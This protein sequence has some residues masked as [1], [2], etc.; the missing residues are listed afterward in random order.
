MYGAPGSSGPA[1]GCRRP[2]PAHWAVL[3]GAGVFLAGC[4]SMPDV[5]DPDDGPEAACRAFFHELDAQVAS[6]GVRDGIGEPPE[7]FPYLRATRF[8]NSFHEQ[9]GD[10]AVR[11]AWLDTAQETDRA[12]RSLELR[13]LD[14][15]AVDGL[16]MPETVAHAQEAIAH[17]GALL[18]EADALDADHGP[19]REAADALTVPD[20]YVTWQRAVG[21]YPI[22]RW[23]IRSGVA[24]WQ[25]GVRESFDN[26]TGDN[27]P[28]RRYRPPSAGTHHEAAG[29]LLADASTNA[30]GWP[31]LS[32]SQWQQVFEQFAP[33]IEVEADAAYN[34]IGAPFL[35]E[36]GLPTVDTTQPTVYTYATATRYGDE[37][38]IQLNYVWW[39]TER[40]LDHWF[41]LLGGRLDGLNLRFTLDGEG[42]VLLVESVHNCGCYHQH[43][44]VQGLSPRESPD[45]AE[46]PLVLP[47]PQA[48]ESGERLRVRLED[49]THYVTHL[50]FA[51][52]P[53]GGEAYVFADYDR[54]RSV[55]V[56]NT[57]QRRSLFQPDGLIAG[58]ER[59]ERWLFWVSGVPQA[60]T[61]R[62]YH[63]HATAFVGR[64]HFDAPDL[65]ERIYEREHDH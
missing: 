28:A 36:D 25:S 39:F 54:L 57:G 34:R 50:A 21:V 51:Q 41:D 2:R 24:V 43:Y 65:L 44:P 62:Q 3:L 52:V 1:R 14:A 55:P 40:P 29:A 9:L 8:L 13:H 12:A 7:A 20:E 27:E 17:C 61:Q 46:P 22:S 48:P 19:W 31:E 10:A 18:R 59:R 49:G 6:A 58:S 26:E 11:G 53:D 35:V 30:L 23:F 64:R 56:V 38:L 45:Y 60:G 5:P 33:V 37:T 16:P 42:D 4:A 32:S 47:G 63:R 15:G